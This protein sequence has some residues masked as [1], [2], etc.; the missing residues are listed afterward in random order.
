MIPESSPIV[1]KWPHNGGELFFPCP[2]LQFCPYIRVL[3]CV[4]SSPGAS[5][6]FLQAHLGSLEGR[7]HEQTGLPHQAAVDCFRVQVLH[8]AVR[9]E[10]FLV[11]H[12]ILCSFFRTALLPVSIHATVLQLQTK[13]GY[14]KNVALIWKSV[15]SC[16]SLNC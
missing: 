1:A 3:C 10:M 6:A 16:Q 14:N 2:R 9:T 13:P 11:P 12:R 4:C 8:P 7:L 15:S 5:F